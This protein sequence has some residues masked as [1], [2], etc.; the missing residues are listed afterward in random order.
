MLFTSSI[1]IAHPPSES[2]IQGRL[3]KGTIIHGNIPN[4]N[5]SLKKHLL[6]IYVLAN[7]IGNSQL[8]NFIHGGSWF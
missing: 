1:L 6:D 5:D 7:G 4:N 3:S 8:V 2:V